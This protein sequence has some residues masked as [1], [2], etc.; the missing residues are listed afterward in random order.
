M[1]ASL[2]RRSAP[3]LLGRKTRVSGPWSAAPTW[4][5]G[6]DVTLGGHSSRV[7]S[8]SKR[9]NVD[10]VSTISK[11]LLFNNDIIMCNRQLLCR[12]PRVR[13]LKF[14]YSQEF[15]SSSNEKSGITE[16]ELKRE[17]DDL[18][19]KFMETR[20][21]LEDAMEAKGTVYFNDDLKD[22]KEAVQETLSQFEDLMVKLSEEQE[23]N[24][25]RTIGLKMEELR[26]QEAMI[27]ESL[28]D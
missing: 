21:L 18:T 2:I 4:P 19:D 7:H 9:L 26:A 25:R 27:D 10:R 20:E 17:I 28:K 15:S 8:S 11:F 16:K 14:I 23:R 12:D 3:C 13:G 5:A 1:M 24:V 22:A 6:A